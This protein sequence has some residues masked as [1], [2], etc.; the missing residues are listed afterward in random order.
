MQRQDVFSPHLFTPF[1]SFTQDRQNLA[2]SLNL[3]CWFYSYTIIANWL[4][5]KNCIQI[6]LFGLDMLGIVI[7]IMLSL[8]LPFNQK[9]VYE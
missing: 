3:S 5:C 8:W 6:F 4:E 1:D 9:N 2:S 7:F